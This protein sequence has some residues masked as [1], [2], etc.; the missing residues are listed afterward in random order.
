VGEF[1]YIVFYLGALQGILLS[2]FLFSLKVNRISNRLLG[3]LTLFWALV[4]IQFAIQ[5]Q[6]ST[7]EFPHL[8][9]TFSSLLLSLFPLQYLFVKYLLYDLKKFRRKDLLH[10]APSIIFVL[11]AY[12]FYFLSGPEKIEWIQNKTHFH[13]VADIIINEV[14][15][16]QGILYSILILIRLSKYKKEIENYDSNVNEVILF[17]LYR[18]TILIFAAWIIGAVAVNL[19]LLNISVNVNLFIIVYLIIVLVIYITSYVVIKT[20]EVFKL[21]AIKMQVAFLKTGEDKQIATVIN[22]NSNIEE[23]ELNKRLITYMENEKPYLDPNINLLQLADKIDAKRNQLSFVINNKH[24]MNFNEFVNSYRVEEVKKLML[25]PA[26][27][28]LKIISLAYDAGFNSK[29]SFNRI[30]KNITGMT[31]SQFYSVDKVG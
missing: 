21:D 3:L 16:A 7:T 18:S 29:A 10:F 8:Y 31:P 1:V 25:D 26:N 19:E 9:R 14:I 28:S 5:S 6:G 15:A 27:D 20:P 30:F 24:E 11:I 17:A 2:V 12:D 22:I 13:Q 4:L 23:E